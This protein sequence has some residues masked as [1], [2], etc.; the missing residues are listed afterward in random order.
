MVDRMVHFT[1]RPGWI[2]DPFACCGAITMES[3]HAFASG[4]NWYMISPANSLRDG[5]GWGIAIQR[6][7]A[8]SWY[9][10]DG[11]TRNGVSKMV[12]GMCPFWGEI[13]SF[14]LETFKLMGVPWLRGWDFTW[15]VLGNWGCGSGEIL[16]NSPQFPISGMLVF[17]MAP[18]SKNVSKW[19]QT[20][21]H[22]PRFGQCAVGFPSS[23]AW[24]RRFAVPSTSFIAGLGTEPGDIPVLADHLTELD[25]TKVHGNA[26]EL[27]PKEAFGLY[28]T[29]R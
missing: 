1:L 24:H 18:W 27:P 21:S 29:W 22:F 28:G 20:T 11:S 23:V 6:Y 8:G 9:F 19:L 2:R 10:I 7:I 17:P 25:T 5:S 26:I 16:L 15:H 4:W 14:W 12:F 3:R 13:W